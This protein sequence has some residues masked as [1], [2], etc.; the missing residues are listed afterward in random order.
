MADTYNTI[1]DQGADWYIN[2]IYN[3]SVTITNV[4]GN[5]TLITYTAEN[6]FIPGTEIFIDGIM[7]SQYNVGNVT[8]QNAT[9]TAFTVA[10]SATG[11]YLQGGYAIGPTDIGGYTAK[12]QLRS[13]PESPTAALT[14]QSPTNISM[15]SATGTI[16]VHA[17]AIQT[18]AI[19]TGYYY[20]DLEIYSPSNIVTRVV[21]VQIEVSAEVTR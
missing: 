3:Q 5:G 14:L 16:A 9:P 19:N 1:I 11:L 15:D 7:P 2:F 17:T 12:L 8:I 21:Q 4:V 18:G 13:L 20:Y 10:L 6:S